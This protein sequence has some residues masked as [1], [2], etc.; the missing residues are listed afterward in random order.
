MISAFFLAL[1]AAGL[2]SAAAKMRESPT[3]ADGYPPTPTA[4]PQPNECAEAGVLR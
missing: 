2:L 3:A 4:A 1:S